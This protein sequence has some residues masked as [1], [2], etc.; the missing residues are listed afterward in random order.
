MLNNVLTRVDFPSPDSPEYWSQKLHACTNVLVVDLPTTMTLKLNPF[1][2]LL[3]C[4][5]FGRLANPTK[6]VNFLRTM[7][8]MSLAAAAAALGS[9]WETVWI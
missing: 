3:R 2:T 5:W 6:P 1:L 8:F 9:L 7:F 4:H